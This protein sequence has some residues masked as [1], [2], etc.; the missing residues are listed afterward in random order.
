M[1]EIADVENCLVILVVYQNMIP[2]MRATKRALRSGRISRHHHDG[3]RSD[4]AIFTR[5]FSKKPW[6]FKKPQV[7]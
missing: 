1:A 3:T 6:V 2:D 7:F 4:L 5:E